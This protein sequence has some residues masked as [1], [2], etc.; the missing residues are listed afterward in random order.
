[1]KTLLP[2]SVKRISEVEKLK[3]L[4]VGGANGSELCGKMPAENEHVCCVEKLVAVLKQFGDNGFDKHSDYYV[5]IYATPNY[6]PCIEVSNESILN[7]LLTETLLSV[8][9]SWQDEYR[10]DL[11]NAWGFTDN[12]F[13]I[14]IERDVIY[15]YSDSDAIGEALGLLNKETFH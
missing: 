5:D 2:V 9:Q 13:N 12:D 15:W 6:F 8:V 14:L 10:V 1:M 4:E 3:Y 11:C 7:R